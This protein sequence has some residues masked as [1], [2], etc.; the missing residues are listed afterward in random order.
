L[1]VEL[2]IEIRLIAEE[3]DLQD[4]LLGFLC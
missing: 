2:Q 4:R 3:P 1:A